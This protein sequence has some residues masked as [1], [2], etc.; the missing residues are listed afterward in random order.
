[1]AL[2]SLETHTE[3]LNSLR[4]RIDERLAKYAHFPA[5]CPRELQAA[6][7]YCLLAP[8]KRLRPLIVLLANQACGG[9]LTTAL[10]AACAVEM[11]HTYSLVHDDLPAMDDD[12]LRRGRPSCHIRFGE[13][14][15]ILV[16]DAL[17]TQAFEVLA[18]DV[19]PAE[20]AI[21]CI[22][23]LSTA[24]GVCHLIG[25]QA[26]DLAAENRGLTI[27]ELESIHVRKTAAL[28]S[29]AAF[30]G[31]LTAGV[32]A[33]RGAHLA[34][35]GRQFGL[36]FQIVDDLL[37]V[38]GK[39]DS[40][41]KQVQKDHRRGKSTYPQLVGNA[42]SREQSRSLIEQ[43]IEQLSEFGTQADPLRHLVEQLVDRRH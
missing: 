13:A 2:G 27:D 32:D 12:D 9:S 29:A 6:I 30:I 25:G 7:Q 16:G 18:T 23:V 40:M 37:D 8:G 19:R 24:A 17:L 5:G 43:A 28:F 21:R 20:T 1:M 38:H 31:G 36:S 22:Q 42:K 41:G 34:E 33:H 4:R 14:T 39:A 35:F 26:D 11:V 3:V 10:G 15:A